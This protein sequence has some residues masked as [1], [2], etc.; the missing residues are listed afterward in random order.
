[1]SPPCGFQGWG[2]Q[3][4]RLGGMCLYLL[5]LHASPG[6]VLRKFEHINW[7]LNRAATSYMGPFF[8]LGHGATEIE[9]LTFFSFNDFH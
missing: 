5:H 9:N 6:F 1:M 8:H 3:I 4:V 7:L 2:T